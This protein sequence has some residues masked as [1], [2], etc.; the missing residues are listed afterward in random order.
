MK[1]AAGK[2]YRL[3]LYVAGRSPRSLSAIVNLKRICENYLP[4]R[5][6]IQIIDLGRH[7]EMASEHQILALPTLVRKLPEPVRKIL[8]DLSNL[9]KVLVSLDLS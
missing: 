2:V 9:E 3:K 4:G 8:G 6:S 1:T 7:P 5:H